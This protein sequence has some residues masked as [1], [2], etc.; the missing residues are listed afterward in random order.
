MA[1]YR[2]L[3]LPMS[4]TPCGLT[5]LR[6]GID[7]ARRWNAHL[8]AV[9]MRVD[10]RSVAPLAGEGLSGAMIEDMMHATERDSAGRAAALEK[11]FEETLAEAE[12]AVD[13]RPGGGVGPTASLVSYTG[14]DE[15][16]IPGLAM[17]SDLTILPHPN[18]ADSDGSESLHAVLFDSGRPVLIAPP[19][20][21]EAATIGR[22]CCLAWNGTVESSAALAAMLPWLRRAEA[23]RV[24]HAP[25]YQRNGPGAPAVLPYLAMHGVQADVVSFQ[26][27]NRDVGAGLLAAAAAFDADLLGM[28]AYSTSRLRQLI[29]G[30]VTRHVLQRARLPV[31]MCR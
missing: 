25:E 17:L 14:R 9:V 26:P 16:V 13:S 24:L 8:A 18:D 28:G 23:V 5:A 19:A 1:H 11:I 21:S 15:D 2:K 29:L 27:E 31:L 22:R 10:A 6:L 7:V 12:I 20:E 30:G 3:L 4:E